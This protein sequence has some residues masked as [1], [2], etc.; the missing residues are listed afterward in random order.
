MGPPS[1]KI[2]KGYYTIQKIIMC[3]KCYQTLSKEIAEL[4][5]LSPDTI[6]NIRRRQSIPKLEDEQK[7]LKEDFDAMVPIVL[8]WIK[9]FPDDEQVHAEVIKLHYCNIEKTYNNLQDDIDICGLAVNA[10]NFQKKIKE[11]WI[12][13]IKN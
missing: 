12:R 10:S 4:K 3:Q 9:T 13:Q 11:I 1:V 6:S 8:E 5:K 2:M 7:A